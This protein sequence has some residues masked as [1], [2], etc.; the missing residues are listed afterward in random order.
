MTIEKTIFILKDIEGSSFLISFESRGIQST[1]K[2]Q[3]MG[4]V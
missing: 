2:K 4:V 1:E 3:G